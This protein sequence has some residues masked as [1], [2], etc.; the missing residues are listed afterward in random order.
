MHRNIVR[1][2]PS[3]RLLAANHTGQVHKLGVVTSP[4]H[5]Q[6]HRVDALLYPPHSRD[7]D[8]LNWPDSSGMISKLPCVPVTLKRRRGP[9]KGST[10]FV[11]THAVAF[12]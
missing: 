3:Q 9:P 4:R 8:R 10:K 5:V 12:G 11:R 1:G 7:N 6:A 2:P